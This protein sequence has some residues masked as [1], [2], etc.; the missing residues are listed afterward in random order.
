MFIKFKDANWQGI[1]KYNGNFCSVGFNGTFVIINGN[2]HFPSSNRVF[3]SRKVIIWD[4]KNIFELK[5]N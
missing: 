4:G 1:I 3:Q 2:L 5:E